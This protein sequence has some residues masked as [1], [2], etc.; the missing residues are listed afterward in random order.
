MVAVDTVESGS[1]AT[2]PEGLPEHGSP[3]PVEE[4][5]GGHPDGGDR[6]QDLQPA[7]NAHRSS[8]AACPGA[9]YTVP[10]ATIRVPSPAR[11][12]YPWHRVVDNDLA[13]ADMMRASSISSPFC[14]R[15]GAAFNPR[16]A[17][18]LGRCVR[19]LYG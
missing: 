11:R 9:G 12:G 10:L 19:C 17:P 13:N 18:A 2:G 14:A 8:A 5:R 7:K 6:Q 1:R 3:D 15:C 4:V 16:T